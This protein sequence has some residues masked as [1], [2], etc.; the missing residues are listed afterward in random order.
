MEVK[1]T[2]SAQSASSGYTI[3][4]KGSDWDPSKDFDLYSSRKRDIRVMSEKDSEFES[5]R[6]VQR[7]MKRRGTTMYTSSSRGYKNAG[8]VLQT[9]LNDMLKRMIS[10]ISK[11]G[12][13]IIKFAGD[14]LIVMH[15]K[16]SKEE[17]GVAVAHTL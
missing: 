17:V 14:A 5:S 2:R 13:D 11:A 1:K 6:R 3:S 9:Y 8:D 7:M 15:K 4:H 12:L 10:T 16:Y